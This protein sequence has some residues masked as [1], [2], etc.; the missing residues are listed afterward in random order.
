[1][2]EEPILVSDIDIA[3]IAIGVRDALELA[4]RNDITGCEF[5]N[6]EVIARSVAWT[7]TPEG[8]H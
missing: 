8:E 3:R 2:M 6:G 5:I 7:C 4:V 1:M